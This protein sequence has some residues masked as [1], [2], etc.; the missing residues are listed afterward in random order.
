MN[1]YLDLTLSAIAAGL[2]SA[3]TIAATTHERWA[4]GIAFINGVA[5]AVVQH[6]R[7][8]PIQPKGLE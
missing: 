8:P 4:I 1:P 7:R 5:I 2:V 6:L 3:T